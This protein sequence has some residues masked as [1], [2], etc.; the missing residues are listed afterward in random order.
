M[1][2][3]SRRILVVDD[4]ENIRR[5]VAAVLEEAGFKVVQ[6]HNAAM[7][8]VLMDTDPAI[9]LLVTD[10]EIP[11]ESNGVELWRKARRKAPMLRVLFISGRDPPTL[12]DGGID[13][14]LAKPFRPQELLDRVIAALEPRLGPSGC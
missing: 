7:A 6:A 1:G 8:L 13:A 4:D 14:F 2:T 11:G 9:D 3:L 10:I 12:L 5:Y